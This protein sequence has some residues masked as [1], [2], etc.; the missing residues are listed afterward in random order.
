MRSIFILLVCLP[1]LGKAQENTAVN[2]VSVDDVNVFV[3]HMPVGDYTNLGSV[4]LTSNDG[5]I[6]ERITELVAVAKEKY[7]NALTA[8]Y[9]RGGQVAQCI[10]ENN[11][12]T[13]KEI[14]VGT[15]AVYLF[16]QPSRD[17]TIVTQKNLDIYD[18]KNVSQG[19]Q[20]IEKLITSYEGTNGDIDAVYS[21][22]GT[23][24][25]FIRFE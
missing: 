16:S 3:M 23:T 14:T 7:G 4:N 15:H 5:N 6:G 18:N 20:E 2:V 10:S 25:V 1:L 17:Y 22:N 8:I 11:S 21:L 9:T 12:N 13:A 24:F 19:N